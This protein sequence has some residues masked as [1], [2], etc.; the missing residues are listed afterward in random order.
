MAKE[1]CRP[2]PRDGEAQGTFTECSVWNHMV[3]R[4]EDPE[5]GQLQGSY[6]NEMAKLIGSRE[7][8]WRLPKSSTKPGKACLHKGAIRGVKRWHLAS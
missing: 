8:A 3:G 5:V 2:R 1:Q 6:Q 7:K 4:K